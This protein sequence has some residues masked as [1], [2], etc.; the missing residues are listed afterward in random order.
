[1]QSRNFKLVEGDEFIRS[2]FIKSEEE[3]KT[4]LKSDYE[5]I[6]KG[7]NRAYIKQQKIINRRNSPLLKYIKTLIKAILGKEF[8]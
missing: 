5:N 8:I 2:V 3:T 6:M 7:L 1:M 4:P